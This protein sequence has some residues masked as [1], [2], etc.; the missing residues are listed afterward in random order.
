[1]E[2]ITVCKN[3]NREIV[4]ISKEDKYSYAWLENNTLT[5]NNPLFQPE[6]SKLITTK[7]ELQNMF[8]DFEINTKT[9]TCFNGERLV[10]EKC[11]LIQ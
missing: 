3:Q 4:K 2:V 1:M 8:P 10:S 6:E 9:Q 11:Y 7:D 5:M